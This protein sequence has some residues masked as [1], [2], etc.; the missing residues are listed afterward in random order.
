M[1]RMTGLTGITNTT[2][3]TEFFKMTGLTRMTGR[4]GVTRMTRTFKV[5]C[6]ADGKKLSKLLL[7]V[8]PNN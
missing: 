5:A 2:G 1:T 4:S 8:K 3:M 7:T 6:F